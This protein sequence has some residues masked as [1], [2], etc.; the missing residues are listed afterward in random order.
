[1]GGTT[2]IYRAQYDISASTGNN[3]IQVA[4]D[5][6]GR[7][8][9][10][11]FIGAPGETHTETVTSQGIHVTEPGIYT[12]ELHMDVT[13]QAASSDGEWGIRLMRTNGLTGA[14][15]VV[16]D[17]TTNTIHVDDFANTATTDR[18]YSLDV[19]LV[20][21][22]FD[23]GD[24]LFAEVTFSHAQTT[25]QTITYDIRG[26]DIVVRRYEGE[27]GLAARGV[28]IAQVNDRIA[29]VVNPH[30]L[31]G[32]FI[33]SDDLDS[34]TRQDIRKSIDI[35]GVSLSD[36][37]INFFSNDGESRSRITLPGITVSDEGTVV[38]VGTLGATQIDFRGSS[39][40]VSR[41][42]DGLARVTITGG[43]GGQ[44]T[45]PTNDDIT[46]LIES[47]PDVV[48]SGE[49]EAAMR[50][51]R[52]LVRGTPTTQGLSNAAGRITGNPTT[53]PR[54]ED[55]FLEVTVAGDAVHRFL[56]TD[57]LD[58]SAVNDSDQLNSGNS[59]T[60][61]GNNSSVEYHIAHA[62]NGEI[63]FAAADIGS[64][65]LTIVADHIDLEGFARRSQ[66]STL[67]PVGK[68]G[69]G[70]TGADKVLHGDGSWQDS[71]GNVADWAEDG[72]TDP[73]PANKLTNA[74]TGSGDVADWA[75]DGNTDPI[76]AA[77]LTNADDAATW[78]EDGNTDLI[79]V[80]KL[81]QAS[82]TEDGI[83]QS[84]EYVRINNSIDA[85]A[86]HSVPRISNAGVEGTDA[87]LIDDSSITVG[88]HL[89]EV[90]FSELDKRWNDFQ[91]TPQEDAA[92]SIFTGTTGWTASTTITVSMDQQTTK[93][94]ASDVM[95]KT[96]VAAQVVGPRQTNA[97]IS[98]R[99][100]VANV[101]VID[102][103]RVTSAPLR[104]QRHRRCARG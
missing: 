40:T 88:S 95:G 56:Q 96:Y 39:V 100:P 10:K 78:A 14:Q 104:E 65:N 98:A 22:R 42:T 29:A 99:V 82:S 32:N 101:N 16:H 93:P 41:V 30:A 102:D 37:D 17:S 36:R 77:K 6:L 45:G 3:T 58:L 5:T 53:G 63:L 103:N 9:I 52:D 83:I 64:Y 70:T 24:Y 7:D 80:A 54:E 35:N 57:L 21:S 1:M 76:P 60:W 34:V 50:Y 59:I 92:L 33:S 8:A 71:G 84:E 94:T 18:K 49:F 75:E 85:R 89:R 48:R 23:E 26:G 20:M 28:T 44:G 46:S 51:K 27:Q 2:V 74:P 72:N 13:I 31:R 90:P 68:L 12:A 79:P 15:E 86:L 38:D 4:Q 55:M 11:T 66:D 91:L 87:V 43:T 62:S 67:V 61:T 25:V 47:N 97:W 69:T 73:I 19:Q 81:P